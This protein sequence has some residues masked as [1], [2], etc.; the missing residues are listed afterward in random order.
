VQSS[1]S[2]HPHLNLFPQSIHIIN[3]SFNQSK[4]TENLTISRT[5]KTYKLKLILKDFISHICSCRK[6]QKVIVNE[7]KILENKIK[8]SLSVDTL[9]E[10]L[11]MIE[12]L[13]KKLIRK[14]E[15]HQAIE[16]MFIHNMLNDS[17]ICFGKEIFSIDEFLI[18]SLE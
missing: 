10:K 4:L 1:I 9:V 7:K 14:K 8:H 5:N 2:F 18:N 17:K 16:S 6:N 12:I 11:Y 13:S 3:N 15:S